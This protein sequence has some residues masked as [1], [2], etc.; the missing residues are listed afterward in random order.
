MPAPKPR[1]TP[2]HAPDYADRV[3]LI[4]KIKIDNAWRFAPVVPE[5][6]SILQNTAGSGVYPC[7]N[8]FRMPIGIMSRRCV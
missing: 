7:R 6:S 4:K 1:T 8:S 3:N 5:S 2:L